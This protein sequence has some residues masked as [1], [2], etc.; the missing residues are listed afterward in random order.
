MEN[1]YSIWIN[2]IFNQDK[3]KNYNK[4]VNS[5]IYKIKLVINIFTF[6]LLLFCLIPSNIKKSVQVIFI[7]HTFYSL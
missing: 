7:I 5:I 2:R 6:F 4:L 1:F 3:H